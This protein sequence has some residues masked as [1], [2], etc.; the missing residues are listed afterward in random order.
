MPIATNGSSIEVSNLKVL[1]NFAY[2]VAENI[3]T[4]DSIF[5]YG[6]LGL[7]LIHI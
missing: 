6:Q 3:T 2:K 5:L 1:K 7:S 4:G